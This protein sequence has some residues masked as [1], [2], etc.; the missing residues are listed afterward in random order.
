[1]LHYIIDITCDFQHLNVTHWARKKYVNVFLNDCDACFSS[2]VIH[3]TYLY[4]ESPGQDSSL[5]Q[6]NHCDLCWCLMSIDCM[7]WLYIILLDC[8]HQLLCK[9]YIYWKT[10][11]Q[12]WELEHLQRFN[13]KALNP[14]WIVWCMHFLQQDM[15]VIAWPSC[16]VWTNKCILMQR[17][18]YSWSGVWQLQLVTIKFWMMR[19]SNRLHSQQLNRQVAAYKIWLPRISSGYKCAFRQ[20]FAMCKTLQSTCTYMCHACTLML[21][22]LQWIDDAQTWALNLHD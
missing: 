5:K 17:N 13:K 14:W 2:I 22:Y 8:Q 9:P 19:L 21:W 3:Q 10:W 6:I 11:N 20:M 4:T 7:S 16:I 15:N 1:M 12:S 18:V